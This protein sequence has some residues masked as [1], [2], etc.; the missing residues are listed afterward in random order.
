MFWCC[1]DL[2]DL[3]DS[4]PL[5][6]RK[7]IVFESCLRTLFSVCAVCS[8]ACTVTLKQIMG[9]LVA[10]TSI[11]KRTDDHIRVWYS[12]PVHNRMP[13]G[14]LM[15]AA[16]S[17]FSGC[18]P[19]MALNLFRHMNVGIYSLKTYFNLQR[20]YLIPAIQTFWNTKQL[21]MMLERKG[22]PLRLGGDARCCSP[23]HTAKYGSYSLMDLRTGEVLTTH[24]VQVICC[25]SLYNK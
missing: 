23:G 24:L 3:V 25:T 11:C 9:T 18:S 8:G 19:I 17:M 15:I 7:F 21:A 5:T 13:V 12:Q 10:V 16:A 22:M 2:Q 20:S 1:S 14:N 6:E 4:S